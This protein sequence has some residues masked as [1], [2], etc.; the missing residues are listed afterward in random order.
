MKKI[1]LASALMTAS[2]AQGSDWLHLTTANNG[3]SIYVDV[4]SL[5]L[6]SAYPEAWIKNVN[7]KP[8]KQPWGMEKSSIVR[9]RFDCKRLKTSIVSIVS[10]NSQ[11][12]MLSSDELPYDEWHNVVPD[13]VGEQI[14]SK[15]CN[16]KAV[17]EA[18]AA[19]QSSGGH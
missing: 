18:I 2:V 5:D 19:E 14:L 15:I 17:I 10:Y 3:Q 12:G 4:E 8:H 7:L 6:T 11:G 1:I 9:R 13:S 16:A